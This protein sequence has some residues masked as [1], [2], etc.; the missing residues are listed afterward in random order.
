MILTKKVPEWKKEKVREIVKRMKESK[1]IGIVEMKG[2]PASELHIIRNKLRRFMDLKVVKKSILR[3]AL[4]E[5]GLKN[6]EKLE[7]KFGEMPAIVFSN[8]DPF[9]LSK[10][11]SEN[12]TPS[13]AKPGQ[14]AQKD[15]VIQAGPTPFQPGPMLSELKAKGL[16]VKVEGGKIVIKEDH[17]I[18]KNGEVI[19]EEIAN[20]LSKLGIKPMEIGLELNCAWENGEVFGREV[21]VFKIDEEINKLKKAAIDAFNLS[22][23]ISYPTKENIFILITKA[24]NE[25]KALSKIEGG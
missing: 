25:A 7:D 22:I 15:I 13:Q 4:K 20:L 18:V 21:L 17:L 16:K 1:T 24:Y 3:F 10:L 23:G 6:I 12:R 9:K 19:S 8:L 14:I 2:M 5:C 11:F